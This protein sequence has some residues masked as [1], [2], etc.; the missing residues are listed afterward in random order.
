MVLYKAALIV[1]GCRLSYKTKDFDPALAE[2]L[3]IMVAMYQIA[4]LSIIALG[5]MAMG[6]NA[7]AQAFI[8][9]VASVVGSMGVVILIMWPKIV[10]RNKDSNELMAAA[11]KTANSTGGGST[12]GTLSTQSGQDDGAKDL[13]ITVLSEKVKNLEKELANATGKSP[14]K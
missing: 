10:R 13:K 8:Q 11:S 7:N 2:S 14:P 6:V 1:S 3:Y 12:V 9:C 5:I 4:M